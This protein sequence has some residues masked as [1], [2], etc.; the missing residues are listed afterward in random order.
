[1]LQAFTK[2]FPRAIADD[3]VSL[4]Y[5]QRQKSRF[6]V[7]SSLGREIAVLLPRGTVLHDGDQLEVTDGTLL[8]VIAT[9]EPLS[10]IECDS[11]SKLA[12]AAYHLGNRHVA[13]EVGEGYLAY[14]RDHVLDHLLQQLGFSVHSVILPFEPEPG[15]YQH[16]DWGAPGVEQI[17]GDAT[18]QPSEANP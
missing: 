2:S 1:M 10:R 9:P 4:D 3:S 13:L 16:H 12:R 8:Q 5:A 11:G 17:R 18:A 14:Q 15:A 7:T 6:R